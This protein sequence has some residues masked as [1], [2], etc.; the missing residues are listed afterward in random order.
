VDGGSK[1]RALIGSVFVLLRGHP[2]FGIGKHEAASRGS[3]A[4]GVARSDHLPAA[5]Q[6]AGDSS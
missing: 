2:V 1:R 5:R 3:G 4:P 6:A